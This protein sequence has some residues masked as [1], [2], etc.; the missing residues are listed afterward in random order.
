MAVS[1]VRQPMGAGLWARIKQLLNLGRTGTNDTA[2]ARAVSA[3][4]PANRAAR[5]TV[6]PNEAFTPTRPRAGRRALV[7]R[8]AELAIAL[9]ALTDEAA[10]IVLYSERGR[11][12]TSLANLV[13]ERLRRSGVIVGRHACDAASDFDQIIRGLLR[14]LPASLLPIDEAGAPDGEGCLGVVRQGK[15]LPADIAAIP[16]QLSC[17]KLVFVVDEFDRVQDEATRTRLADTIKMLSDRGDRLLFMIVG[18]STTLEHILGQHPSIERNITSLHL[19]LLADDEIAE[20]LTRGGNAIG[21]AFTD[22]ACARVAGVARGMP[23]MAQL[24]GLR[25][26]QMALLRGAS[27]TSAADVAAA[28]E[29]LVADVSPE[30]VGKYA[31]LMGG[32]D[33]TAM[34]EA[35]QDIAHAPQDKWGRI[36]LPA[37]L[38]TAPHMLEKLLNGEVLSPA[39][40]APGLFQYADRKLIYYVLLLAARNGA[41]SGAMP[42]ESSKVAAAPRS[43]TTAAH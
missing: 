33:G 25:I 43:A 8:H 40:G 10:H 7:G 28:V 22:A 35:L 4:T 2:P 5:K 15:L 20:M 18:V 34:V 42:H 21:I 24:M 16:G 26:T 41:A 11:G 3:A 36:T 9:Q 29:R 17:D 38:A 19:P 13:V 30:T 37:G 27:E 12:K 1:G 39:A 31:M 23:Y 14:D 32:A 6:A